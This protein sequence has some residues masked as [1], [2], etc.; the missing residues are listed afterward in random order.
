VTTGIAHD[1]PRAI[2]AP[3]DGAAFEMVF[4]IPVCALRA[5]KCRTH[6]SVDITEQNG[7]AIIT[8]GAKIVRQDVYQDAVPSIL[9]T[10]FETL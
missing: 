7:K 4:E 1:E 5:E 2:N 9:I 8:P 10:L 3:C 6:I